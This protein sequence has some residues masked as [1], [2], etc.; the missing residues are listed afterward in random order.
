MVKKGIV[1]IFC[2]RLLEFSA[3]NHRN[4]GELSCSYSSPFLIFLAL[5]F[6]FIFI[7]RCGTA[8][9][10]NRFYVNR[11]IMEKKYEKMTSIEDITVI[12]KKIVLVC[13]LD[14]KKLF[15]LVIYVKPIACDLFSLRT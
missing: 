10:E 15:Y 7:T 2:Q 8:F 11:P 5:I 14:L 9:R 4:S 12:L 3:V 1:F 13:V 6:R